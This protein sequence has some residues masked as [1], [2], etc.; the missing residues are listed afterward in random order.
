MSLRFRVI[1]YLMEAS[2][3]AIFRNVL[4][5]IFSEGPWF[6]SIFETPTK[7]QLEIY[8][9]TVSRVRFTDKCQLGI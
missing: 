7:N 5:L 2:V 9:A 4:M 1:V 3:T 6:R 8:L